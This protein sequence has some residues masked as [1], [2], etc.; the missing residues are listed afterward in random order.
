MSGLNNKTLLKIQL[1]FLEIIN[2]FHDIHNS[3]KAF[4]PDRGL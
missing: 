2:L 3:T 4:S 1:T